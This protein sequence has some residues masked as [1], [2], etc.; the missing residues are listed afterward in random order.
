M[1]YLLRGALIEYGS[2]FLGPIPNVVI[3]QFNPETMTREIQIPTRPT[4]SGSREVSQAGEIPLERI[5]ITAKFS[6]ADAL[7]ENNPL[8]RT[9][10]I[11]PRLAALEKMVHPVGKL[12]GLI[13]EAIDQVANA[14]SGSSDEE[15]SIPVPRENYPR[16][17][18]IWGLTR[19]LPV[20]ITSMRIEEKKYDAL[21]NPVEAEV[22]LGLT[23]MALDACSED[24]IAKGAME[25]TNLAKDAM[26]ISNLVE[27]VPQVVEIIPF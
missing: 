2:D 14:I 18:F 21:L 22:S 1:T 11:G 27:T 24:T 15:A 25:Y 9:V 17:L 20:I 26:A 7:S 5:T 19:V 8:A 23:V 12:S 4:G 16:I 13:G 10:G 3:F 6:A